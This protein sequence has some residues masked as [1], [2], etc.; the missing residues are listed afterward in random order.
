MPFRRSDVLSAC[1]VALPYLGFST[2]WI[3]VTDRWATGE[4]IPGL[5]PSQVQTVK[6][7]AFVVASSL[8]VGALALY[9]ASSRRWAQESSRRV[10]SLSG[11][12]LAAHEEERKHLARDLQDE[13]GQT[14]ALAQRDLL[15]ALEGREPKADAP[16]AKI[17]SALRRLETLQNQLR[18]IA[19]SLRPSMLDDLGLRSALRWLIQRRW[20]DRSET[21]RLRIGVDEED[22]PRH[23]A[24]P[25]FRIAQE[26][27][28]N[29]LQHAGSDHIEIR[30]DRRSDALVLEVVDDGRGFDV[31][32]AKTQASNG[33]SL[34]LLRLEEC[35]EMM[36]GSLSIRS[37]PGGGTSVTG[38][39]PVG[40]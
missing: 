6:G 16:G 5:E 40:P 17:E 28:S 26:A 18:L 31:R 15:E 36:G 27:L 19:L 38:R 33:R 3:L 21:I 14:A 13:L 25:I 30:L 23:M 22:I 37:K 29:A 7:L 9:Q 24:L 32:S 35:A 11:R 34:G 10:A 4:V 1:A 39:F 20:G 2:L 8:L 12:F